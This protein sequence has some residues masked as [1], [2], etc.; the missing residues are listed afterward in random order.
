MKKIEHIG[1]AVKSI[2]NANQ[3]YTSLLGASP[4]KTEEV[5]SEGVKTSFFKIG[6]N[7]IELLEFNNLSSTKSSSY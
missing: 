5:K 2:E 1:I 4:Y 3:I 7:K 6:N